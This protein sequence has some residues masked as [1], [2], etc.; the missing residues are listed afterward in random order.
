[1]GTKTK[2]V[3]KDG[4]AII[5]NK[6]EKEVVFDAIEMYEKGIES[7]AVKAEGVKVEN[8]VI[9]ARER[10]TKVDELKQKFL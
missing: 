5:L 3:K 6:W 8:A 9:A 10:M 1:M 2:S 7:L 4:E